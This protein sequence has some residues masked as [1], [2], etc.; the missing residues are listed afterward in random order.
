MLALSPELKREAK[1]GLLGGTG[2]GECLGRMDYPEVPGRLV[3]YWGTW[4][5]VRC[6]R[7]N[8]LP[9]L[10]NIAYAF[11]CGNRFSFKEQSFEYSLSKQRGQKIVLIALL[12]TGLQN[13][14]QTERA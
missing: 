9:L 6:W 1:A 5:C 13:L 12:L 8:G 4:R 3:I 10:I 7:A 11:R 14:S 2:K